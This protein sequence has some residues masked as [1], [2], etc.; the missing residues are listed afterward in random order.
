MQ[1]EIVGQAPSLHS[2]LSLHWLMFLNGPD[3]D[4]TCYT[5]YLSPAMCIFPA[6]MLVILGQGIVFILL[7]R[8]VVQ[9]QVGVGHEGG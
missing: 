4:R 5:F 1:S 3:Q 9:V 2:A 7:L 8:K 6:S